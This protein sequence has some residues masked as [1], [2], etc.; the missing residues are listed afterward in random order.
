MVDEWLGLDG[1]VVIVAG[2]GGGGIGTAVS[3]FIAEAGADVVAVDRD[4]ERLHIT[5]AAL[6]D[7]GRACRAVVADVRDPTQV[8]DAVRAAPGPLHGLVH[9]AG[10]LA[11][12]EWAPVLETAPETFAGIVRLNLESAFLTS[13]AVAG[14]LVESGTPGSIVHIASIAGLS[15]L[16]FGAGYAAA[17][18]GLLGLTRTTAVEWG[19]HG[20]RVNAVAPGTVRTPRN[21]VGGEDVDSPAERA[22]IPLGRRGEPDDIAGAVLFLLSDLARF[23]SGQVLV[24][25]GGSS[26]RP[27]YLDDEDLPVFVRD[28]GLRARVGR[29]HQAKP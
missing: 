6:A 23:V 4:A 26:A 18:A 21:R 22:A 10:G 12:D 19:R 9:V 1:R 25:D 24:V 28:A 5:E 13:R 14:R 2:A 16:P 7:A 11:L 29:S 17:K 3:R 27:S 20:I 8:D 15:S